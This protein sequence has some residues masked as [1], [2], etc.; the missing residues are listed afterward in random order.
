MANASK[1]ADFFCPSLHPAMFGNVFP[2]IGLPSPTKTN[3]PHFRV[4]EDLSVA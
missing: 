4:T 1:G 3:A 2:L